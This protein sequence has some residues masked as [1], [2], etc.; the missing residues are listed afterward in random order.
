MCRAARGFSMVVEGCWRSM[1]VVLALCVRGCC[2]LAVNY[3]IGA[4]GCTVLAR[5]L[6]GGAVPQ[7]SSLDLSGTLV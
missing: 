7:L 6:E 2:G 4:E 5:A 1:G 3:R